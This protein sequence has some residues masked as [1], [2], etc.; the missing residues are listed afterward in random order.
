MLETTDIR[1]PKRAIQYK[2]SGYAKHIGT[3]VTPM[4]QMI[5]SICEDESD[6]T[7]LNLLYANNTKADILLREE[8]DG[9]M[10]QCPNK[11]RV[12]YILMKS[13]FYMS[14]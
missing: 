13:L 5:R 14:K 12:H 6:P 1:G 10:K 2:P 11:F 8:L 7:R 3:G 9:Y 4:F